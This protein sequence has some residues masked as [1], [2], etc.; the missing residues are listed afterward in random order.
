MPEFS[1]ELLNKSHNRKNFSCGESALDRYFYE[2]VTQDIKR[3]ITN[4]FVCVQDEKIAG[5]YTIASSSI[6]I[7]DLPD[8]LTK[9][10]PRYPVVPAILIGRLAV[11]LQYQKQGI[12]SLLLIDVFKRSLHSDIA[13]YAVLVD[14]KNESAIYFY[15]HHGFISFAHKENMLFLPLS[16]V[17]KKLI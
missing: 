11:D 1:L 13:N 8:E 2:Q 4:C 12:G 7:N 5:F 17:A 14:A 3:R 6:P 9:K 10:L 15:R 16:T